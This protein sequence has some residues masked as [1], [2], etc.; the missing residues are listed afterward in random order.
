MI[1]CNLDKSEIVKH[2]FVAGPLGI[3]ID[4][5]VLST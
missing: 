3:H 5:G 4:K 1:I 2:Y